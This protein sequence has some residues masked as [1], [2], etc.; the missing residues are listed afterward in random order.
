MASTEQTSALIERHR[1]RFCHLSKAD[2]VFGTLNNQ[3]TAINI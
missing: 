3:N 2:K 1:M